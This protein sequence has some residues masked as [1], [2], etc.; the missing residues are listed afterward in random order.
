MT[1]LCQNRW[2]RL[3]SRTSERK[4]VNEARKKLFGTGR[5]IANIPPT[6]EAL[7]QHT[8]EQY[9][10][11][12]TCIFG[13]GHLYHI[14]QHDV[15]SLASWGWKGSEDESWIPVWQLLLGQPNPAR[16]WLNAAA[17]NFVDLHADV[18]KPVSAQGYASRTKD[19]F[20]E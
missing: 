2:N 1:K 15:P 17:K 14:P 10:K 19:L 16:N 8:K 11:D 5:Q 6:Q 12:Y 9:I 7:I 18:V 20:L 3:Y 4:F 13:I